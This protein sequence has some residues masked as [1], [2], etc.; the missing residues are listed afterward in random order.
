[1]CLLASCRH[2]LGVINGLLDGGKDLVHGLRAIDLLGD[3]GRTPSGCSLSNS[4]ISCTLC[5][6]TC[7]HNPLQ[8][9]SRGTHCS[10]GRKSAPPQAAPCSS[11]SQHPRSRGKC[12]GGSQP[13]PP[14]RHCAA[15]AA[16]QAGAADRRSHTHSFING[17]MPAADDG[18]STSQALHKPL[19]CGHGTHQPGHDLGRRRL[20]REVIDLSSFYSTTSESAGA[21]V[22]MQ[23][24][25]S[26]QDSN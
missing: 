19:A 9:K 25:T 16:R 15:P 13:S 7:M 18:P 3:A 22:A 6:A 23:S 2:H 10:R 1:M 14:C 4:N 11:Q 26:A 17:T 8:P 5:H 24:A 21:T 20:E 12:A